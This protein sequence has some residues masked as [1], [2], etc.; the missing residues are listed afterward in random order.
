MKYISTHG[1]RE[2]PNER[3]SHAGSRFAKSALFIEDT[4]AVQQMMKQWLW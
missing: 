1:A 3:V 4:T 2:M